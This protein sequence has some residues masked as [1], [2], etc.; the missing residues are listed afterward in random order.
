MPTIKTNKQTKQENKQ[1]QKQT[2]KQ[3]NVSVLERPTSYLPFCKWDQNGVQNVLKVEPLLHPGEF[4]FRARY[5]RLFLPSHKFDYDEVIFH[6]FSKLLFY[7]LL[8]WVN[9][10]YNE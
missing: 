3:K 4:D 9:N 1:K 5:R 7:Q 2:N 8:I 6:E 10:I